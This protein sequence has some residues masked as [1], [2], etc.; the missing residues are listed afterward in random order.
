MCEKRD[1]AKEKEL[2]YRRLKD[3][4]YID[5][6]YKSK[7]LQCK[8]CKYDFHFINSKKELIQLIE[9]NIREENDFSL[10]M[11]KLKT[12]FDY[13]GADTIYFHNDKDENICSCCYVNKP[14][15][16][17]KQLLKEFFTK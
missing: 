1:F 9:D 6:E 17:L 7:V 13:P 16:S 12:I 14:K 11:I 4:V 15:K 5:P 10:E 2:Y 3:D 8:V